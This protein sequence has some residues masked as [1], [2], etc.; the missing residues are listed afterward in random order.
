M[1][2]KTEL[3]EVISSVMS[4]RGFDPTIEVLVDLLNEVKESN[5]YD[6]Y[7]LQHAFANEEEMV[8][9]FF[10]DLSEAL[11]LDQEEYRSAVNAWLPP[12]IE[13]SSGI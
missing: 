9:C 4:Q 11:F 12:G 5:F 1:L 2:P 7:Y 6:P 8:G 13:Y 3:V 10:R